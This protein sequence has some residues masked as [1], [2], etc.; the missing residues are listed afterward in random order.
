M[1]QIFLH[2]IQ[3]M[4]DYA[5]DKGVDAFSLLAI[6]SSDANAYLVDADLWT[7]DCLNNDNVHLNENGLT[8]AAAAVYDIILNTLLI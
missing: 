8:Q 3:K 2:T 4:T 1:T 6:C 7:G 5:A